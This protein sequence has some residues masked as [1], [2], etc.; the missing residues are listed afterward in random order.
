MAK[1]SNKSGSRFF[2]G[3]IIGALVTAGILYCYDT[4]FRKSEIEQQTEKLKKEAQKA[5][6][7]VGESLKD[8]FE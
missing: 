1:K 4:Y 6:K 7:K 3:F 8:V 2:L 5:S